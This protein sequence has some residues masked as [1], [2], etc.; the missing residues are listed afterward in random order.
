MGALS[1]S[2]T[3]VPSLSVG[4][5]AT[6]AVVYPNN[7][8]TTQIYISNTLQGD[9]Y[10]SSA[11][12]LHTVQ[13]VMS[14]DFIGTVTMQATLA[15]TPNNTDW[16]NVNDT[17]SQ[18]SALTNNNASNITTNMVDTYNFVGNFVWVRSVVAIDQGAVFLVQY[19]H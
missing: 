16:F 13:Y 17:T 3:F 15:T 5:T 2:F 10:Y 1:Q 19:N 7:T 14:N 4:N 6:T 9:G 11:D 8:N 12:G 18:Y